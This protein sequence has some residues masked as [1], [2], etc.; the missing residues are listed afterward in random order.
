MKTDKHDSCLAQRGHVCWASASRYRPATDHQHARSGPTQLS[1]GRQPLQ[2][3]A[4]LYVHPGVAW[5]MF[6]DTLDGLATAEFQLPIDP[7]C[8]SSGTP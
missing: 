3:A 4:S 1:V 2:T 6:V 5:Q 7:P 8:T